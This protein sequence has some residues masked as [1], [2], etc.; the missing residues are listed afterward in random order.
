MADSNTSG[1]Q[2]GLSNGTPGPSVPKAIGSLAKKQADVTR[3]GTQKLKFVPTLPARRKKEGEVKQEENVPKPATSER[4]RGRGRGRGEGR[5]GGRGGARGGAP[6][7]EMTASGPFAMGPAMA[8]SS[9][10]RSTPRSNFT[11]IVPLGPGPSSLGAGLTSSAPPALK[12]EKDKDTD[13]V[14]VEDDDEVYSEP[15]EGV[16]IVDMENVRQMDWM[17]PESLRKEKD[18][19]KKKKKQAKETEAAAA[20]VD[21]ANAVDLSESEEEEELEDI[22]EDFAL[23]AEP[24]EESD[25]RQERL[26]FFQFPE[27]FPTFVPR[28]PLPDAAPIDVDM[29]D[30]ST[31]TDGSDA[32]GKRVSFANDTKPPAASPTPASAPGADGIGLAP[33]QKPEEVKL[34]GQ[35]GQLE[36]YQSGAVK[37]R[38]GN[39]ILMDVTAATQP[40]FLQHAVYLD[41][42]NKR[43][44]V[45]GEVNKR[46]VVTPNVDALLDDLASIGIADE[47]QIDE[48]GLFKMDTDS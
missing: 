35:I 10:R 5:G 24:L 31:L 38:L 47:L 15:D 7:V 48:E 46:F 28:Q 23:E 16:E 40:S 36:I 1:S 12:R 26:Y 44:C 33:D 32:K 20:E 39:G 4:G 43:L 45:L 37:M 21:L 42:D 6:P 22:I 14:K 34:D 29:P 2:H 27:P 11:P 19:A 41:M 17:A 18:D 8:G 25:V 9:A 30:P 13:R 3:L